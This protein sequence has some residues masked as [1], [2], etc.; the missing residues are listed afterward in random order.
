MILRIL[1]ILIQKTD[2][3]TIEHLIDIPIAGD[4]I[5]FSFHREY[6]EILYC[7]C[8]IMTEIIENT[9][10]GFNIVCETLDNYMIENMKDYVCFQ[11]LYI[12]TNLLE[13]TQNL[14]IVDISI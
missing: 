3:T 4:C 8:K 9:P 13:K 6:T 5:F 2:K 10:A 14:I 7:V 1:E 11:K 12:F